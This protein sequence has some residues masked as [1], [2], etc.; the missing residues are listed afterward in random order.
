MSELTPTQPTPEQQ[1]FSIV[2]DYLHHKNG[3]RHPIG[4]DDIVTVTDG[5]YAGKS[6][7]VREKKTNGVIVVTEDPDQPNSIDIPEDD[8][9]HFD[10]YHEAMQLALHQI[11][12]SDDEIELTNEPPHRISRTPTRVLQ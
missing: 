7:I 2:K 4:V 9:W 1:R 10:D 12:L 3:S 11:P 5:Q 8:L 6:F